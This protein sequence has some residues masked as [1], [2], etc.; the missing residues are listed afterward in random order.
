[1][2]GAIMSTRN[3]RKRLAK[4]KTAQLRLAVANV[5]RAEAATMAERERIETSFRLYCPYTLVSP[6]RKLRETKGADVVSTR[7]YLD[8]RAFVPLKGDGFGG[9]GELRR[10]YI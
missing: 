7:Q 1:M 5:L 2:K 6:N 10:K 9:K 4:A 3:E 8:E